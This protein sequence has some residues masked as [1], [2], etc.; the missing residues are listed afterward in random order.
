MSLAD[1]IDDLERAA[2]QLEP[3][4]RLKLVRTLADS[5]GELSDE[6]IDRLWLDEAERR[7]RELDE[8]K[9]TAVSGAEV[10]KRLRARYS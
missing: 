10:F 8:G 6:E 4:A 1:S 9:A 5:F 3:D 7:D 2:L